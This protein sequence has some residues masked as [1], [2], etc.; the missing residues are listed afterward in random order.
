M[1]LLLT[2]IEQPADIFLG[3]CPTRSSSLHFSLPMVNK[4]LSCLLKMH[5]LSLSK[6]EA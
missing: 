2:N 5:M 6:Q 4:T 3:M 1:F